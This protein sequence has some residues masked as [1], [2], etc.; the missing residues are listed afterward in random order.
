VRG[1]VSSGWSTLEGKGKEGKGGG[2]AYEL[3]DAGDDL[4]GKDVA[5][6]LEEVADD[7]ADSGERGVVPGGGAVP[8][9]NHGQVGGRR[10]R[11]RV[12]HCA[13]WLQLGEKLR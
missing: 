4:V 9:A 10:G 13:A 12:R 7:G 3:N 5:L 2:G 11:L 1:C 8:G 6:G